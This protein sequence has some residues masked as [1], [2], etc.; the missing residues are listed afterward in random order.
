MTGI[1][2]GGTDDSDLA[3]QRATPPSPFFGSAKMQRAAARWLC[4][5]TYQFGVGLPSQGFP[6]LDENKASQYRIG[7]AKKDH[8]RTP[9]AADDRIQVAG[10]PKEIAIASLGDFAGR[11]HVVGPFDP[12]AAKDAARILAEDASLYRIKI[13]EPSILL[14]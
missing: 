5:G 2:I 11:D 13:L 9:P 1:S 8:S 4:G 14:I 10:R 6:C 12:L 7:S 3:S